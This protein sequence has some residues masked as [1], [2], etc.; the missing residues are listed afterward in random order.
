VGF[1]SNRLYDANGKV[2]TSDGQHYLLSVMLGVTAGR[3]NSIA[4]VISYLRRSA[5]ADGTHPKGTIYF[6][7]NDDIRSKV[8][9]QSFPIVVE[10]LKN[11]G[12]AAEIL[13]GAIP[14]NKTNVQGAV[15]GTA[16]FD[17]KSSGST[18][19]P[20]AICDNFTSFG[21]VM[22]GVEQT[23]LS[24]YL[25]FGAAGAS[26]AVTEP[27]DIIAKFPSPIIQIHYARGCSLAEAFYQSIH[28]PYQ[29]LIVG[30]PL[31]QPWADIPQVS[32]LGI[33]PEEKVNGKLTL[34]PTAT[35]PKSAEVDHFELFIEGM[36]AAECEPGNILPLDTTG[37]ADGYHE[38]RIVAIGPKPIETQGKKIIPFQTAN[39]NRKIEAS[40]V[41][42]QPL[43]NDKPIVVA[44][45][46]PGSTSIIILHG[47]RVVGSLT[48][49][50]GNIE[51]P[52]NTLGAG[53]VLLRV[54]GLGSGGLRTNALAKPLEL[55]VE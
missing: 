24:E 29:L 50:K 49:E 25:R 39:H 53:P 15:T 45:N 16:V 43:Q 17:W 46:S 42:K 13:E 9:D 41:T 6:V 3:G 8:R 23:P 21:G 35:L 40:L 47:S 26:G 36:R 18:I 1:R 2:V 22:D 51:I 10:E 27:Y 38:L 54:V 37:L 30:D 19:L 5:A 12:V 11:L 44:A 31:C 33:K 55:T 32:V 7:K 48:G 20:G 14:L 28:G 4:E 34:T 52:P